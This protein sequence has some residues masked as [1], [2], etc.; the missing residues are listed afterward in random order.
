M[1]GFSSAIRRLSQSLESTLSPSSTDDTNRNNTDNTTNIDNNNNSDEDEDIIDEKKLKRLSRYIPQTT[2]TL[3]FSVPKT[4]G[5]NL[6]VATKADRVL[7]MDLFRGSVIE[8]KEMK[9]V[10]AFPMKNFINT[11]LSGTQVIVQ[12]MMQKINAVHA[13]KYQFESVADARRFHRIVQTNN[14]YGEFI[15]QAFIL[16]VNESRKQLQRIPLEDSHGP[17]GYAHHRSS[18]GAS[19]ASTAAFT[20]A[21]EKAK[22]ARESVVLAIQRSLTSTATKQE[23]KTAIDDEIASRLIHLPQLKASLIHA[24]LYISDKQVENMINNVNPRGVSYMDLYIFLLN[25]PVYSAREILLFWMEF[26]FSKKALEVETN[27]ECDSDDGGED[28]LDLIDIH[29]NIETMNNDDEK[30]ENQ[31][32]RTL[33]RSLYSMKANEM[34][35]T[36]KSGGGQGFKQVLNGEDV[37]LS[38]LSIKGVIHQGKEVETSGLT[39]CGTLYVTNFRIALVSNTPVT[40]DISHDLIHSRFGHLDITEYWKTFSIPLSSIQKIELYQNLGFIVFCKDMRRVRILFPYN[41][42]SKDKVSG[43]C[44]LISK[45]AFP[46]DNRRS[47]FAYSFRPQYD[48]INNC[49]GSGNWK[50]IAP[51]SSFHP[52]NSYIDLRKD[53]TRMGILSCGRW[54][55][56]DNSKYQL[57]S[58]YPPY[59]AIPKEINDQQLLNAANF[60]SKQRVPVITFRYKLSGAVMIRSSQPMVGIT[61]RSC[62]EDIQLLNSYRLYRSSWL[63]NSDSD[64]VAFYILDAR[65]KVAATANKALG[66][67]TEDKTI[68]SNTELEYQ[69]VGNIHVMRNS[70]NILSDAIIP[71]GYGE[72]NNNLYSK[73]EES[74]WLSHISMILQASI[75]GAERMHVRCASILTHCSD[76][77]DRTAQICSLIQ[78]ILD[79]YYRTFDGLAT[80]IEKDWC[81]FGYKFDERT[82][83]GRT[84][85]E[86]PDERSPVF[87]QF[88]DCLW[89][90]YRQYPVA[91][92]YNEE[93][94]VFLVDHSSNALFGNFLG[95]CH[96]IRHEELKVV[97]KTNS[98]W[99]YI[100]YFRSRFTNSNYQ[101]YS[102]PIWPCV[103]LK[104]LTLWPRYYLRWC[105]DVHP[106]A[107]SGVVWND[108][109]W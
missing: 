81:A 50:S 59:L 104:A 27:R 96:R 33:Q 18:S 25:T 51:P 37:I 77:W 69:H 70:W 63:H 2:V 23:N 67:G 76:G 87:L 68:Y 72:L 102:K 82:G 97:E 35:T 109:F 4:T 71:G 61:N 24:D 75:N 86:K 99:E 10:K 44:N 38:S 43:I 106:R 54:R 93:L 7:E 48:I 85:T 32:D 17:D 103:S 47:L 22:S 66:K 11:T 14:E 105:P 55:I 74:G 80:L 21:N 3:H 98:I 73:I 89:Q 46:G 92:E 60:R 45:T 52:W 49:I 64:D 56:F 58:T 5:I 95:D 40:S 107:G 12:K 1:S 30:E 108:S 8:Y 83:C 41:E 88:I 6:T 100:F 9:P 15:S 62:Q 34:E 16:F 31:T 79:P 53:Y 42:Q 65:G 20:A 13:K 39:I 19:K 29:G 36:K 26:S 94:L 91:F 57:C 28:G 84:S 90:I 101:S 78:I